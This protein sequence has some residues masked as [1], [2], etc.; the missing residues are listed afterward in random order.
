[1]KPHR[2]RWF[3]PIL[4]LILCPSL[5]MAQAKYL[6][7][8]TC[9][10]CHS[11]IYE[12]WKM[13]LHNKSQQEQSDRN[14]TVVV[15]WKGVLR[16]K[17]GNI[18][19]YT[20]KLTRGKDGSYQATLV[21]TKNPAR[22]VTYRVVRTYGG[23]GWKQRY[24]VKIGNS[25]YILPIQWNQ[26]TSRWVT[27]NPQWW[28][29]E[30]G[31]LK[32]PQVKDSF[33]MG[34]AGCHNTGLELIKTDKGYEAKY[35]ELNAGCE[36]CHGPGS[37]HIGATTNKRKIMNPKWLVYDR[38]NEVCGQCHSRGVSKPNG[39]FGYPV[40][41][42]DI[43]PYTVGAVLT[44]FYQFKPGEWGGMKAHAKSHHQQWHDLQRS[45]HWGK[46]TCYTC[47]DPHGGPSVSQL[48][49]ADYDNE[50]CLSCHGRK[51]KFANPG[52]I[53]KHTKHNYAPEVVGLSRCSSCHM[54]KTAASA[55]AGDVHSH[56]FK[57]IKPAESLEM[58]KEDPKN[59]VSNSCNGC[60]KNW[61]KDEA[62]YTAG[63]RAYEKIF[64][65]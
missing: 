64:G 18:P 27:Y 4:I 51:D 28:Y 14:D 48:I 44:D 1:M 26:T 59:V 22:E 58:F 3:L 30:D 45:K 42:K 16:L 29:N 15:D 31:S 12:K 13:T 62:G 52:A 56:D 33:E 47:H 61:A 23:W 7:S 35:V 6:G 9:K 65:K 8:E 32:Q 57:I 34:C 19:E 60:H 20:V 39:T 43:K 50:L 41:D 54:V 36:K 5:A 40:N 10:A 25:H 17:G 63:V 55:E 38:A 21:D 53:R 46:T 11:G 24:Q 2:Y 37:E 49:K